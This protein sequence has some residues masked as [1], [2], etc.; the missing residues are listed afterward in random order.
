[1]PDSTTFGTY[2][3]AKQEKILQEFMD[4]FK[5]NS[6]GY[7]VGEFDGARQR[8]EDNKWTPGHVRWTWGQPGYGQYRAHLMGELLIGV[9]VLCDDGCVWFSCLDVDDY[10]IDYGDVMQRV[11]AIAL[12]LCVFRTKSGGLRITLFFDEPISAEDLI[13]RMGKLSA[14]LGYA[15]CEIFPKQ[16]KLLV[17]KG[18]CPSW[19]YLPYSGTGAY[20]GEPLFAEAGCMNDGG[21][22]MEI[23]LAMQ[24]C[25]ERRLNKLSFFNLFSAEKAA[26][27]NGKKN[28]K[29]HPDRIFVQE[30][31]HIDT[32]DSVFHDGPVCLR[33][34]SRMGVGQGQ[35]NHFLTMCGIFLL[36]KYENW[37]EALR[38]VNTSI[39]K[40]SGDPGKLE[41]MIKRLPTQKYDYLCHDEPMSTF[42]DA[43]GCRNKKYG[44]GTNGGVDYPELGMTIVNTEPPTYIIN[45]GTKR[46]IMDSAELF[47]VRTFQI[48][49]LEQ[50]IHIPATRKQN[51]HIAWIN[52]LLDT[53]TEVEPKYIMRTNAAELE[54]LHEYFGRHVPI[55]V[56]RGQPDDR[57]DSVRVKEEESRIYFKTDKLFEWMRRSYKES[58]VKAMRVFLADKGTEHKG[59]GHWWRY[60]TSVQF[61]VFEEEVLERWLNPE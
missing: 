12:P 21:N 42:C 17:D 35:Q 10:E 59:G 46:M 14:M 52:G 11:R 50:R 6:R 57:K 43:H 27:A 25:L 29:R 7:G 49:F 24:Y 47:S 37:S 40:P 23:D 33:I 38:W 9:G 5:G 41:S 22:L 32:V 16:T 56:R 54:V 45:V 34:L 61:D 58:D 55:W 8:E 31:N 48:K 28:G 44:V 39:L 4:L 19:I 60:T 1:M 15:G 53:A 3:N 30:E 26:D 2:T 13:P 18:D 20:S 36:R 51:D